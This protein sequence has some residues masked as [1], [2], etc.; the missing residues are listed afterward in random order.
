L[1]TLVI[2]EFNPSEVNEV[3]ALIKRTFDEFVGKEYSPQG[4]KTF[5]D[6]IKPGKIVE[7][8]RGGNLILEVRPT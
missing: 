1:S 2:E 5:R 7:R 6:F 8:L 4:Q 3:Y